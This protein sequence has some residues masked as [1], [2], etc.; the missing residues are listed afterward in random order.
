MIALVMAGGKGTRMNFT[1]EKLLLEY[2]KP[3]VLR[4]IDALKNSGCFSKILVA[5]SKNSPK[6]K[7][8]L[9]KLDVQVIDTPGTE[10][11]EDL[12]SV[13]QS[14]SDQ[15][16]VVSG[17]LAL[18]DYVVIR[19]I[20]EKK[21][22]VTWMSF[23]VTRD[24]LESLELSSEYTTK[25]DGKECIYTG[26]SLIDAEKIS[27]LKSVEEHFLIINDKKIAFNLNTQE[28]YNLLQKIRK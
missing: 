3:I 2:E 13:L 8:L 22:D 19:K 12:N 26:I 28:D 7:E 25:F 14:L 6:T 20:V 24:F 23:L 17:D 18:L 4:V 10:Y 27:D 5:T 15:V 21:T 9:Q 11:T 16:L 1:K